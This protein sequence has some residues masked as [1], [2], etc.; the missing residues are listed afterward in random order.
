MFAF[1]W[2]KRKAQ[3]SQCLERNCQLY[4]PLTYIS[5][6]TFMDLTFHKLMSQHLECMCLFKTLTCSP[7]QT[8]TT[9]LMWFCQ[10][11]GPSWCSLGSLISSDCKWR[12]H[13]LWSPREKHTVVYTIWLKSVSSPLLKSHGSSPWQFCTIKGS[14]DSTSKFKIFYMTSSWF[15]QEM[16]AWTPIFKSTLM[17]LS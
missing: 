15:I 16:G 3:R 5:K 11:S 8:H 4:L 14:P 17:Q 2:Q 12:A 1:L 7:T 6:D 9:E 13:N 10:C